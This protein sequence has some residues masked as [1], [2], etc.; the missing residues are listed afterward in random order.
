MADEERDH[1]LSI[2]IEESSEKIELSEDEETSSIYEEQRVYRTPS[3]LSF[4][5]EYS[6]EDKDRPPIRISSNHPNDGA[7]FSLEVQPSTGRKQEP[8]VTTLETNGDNRASAMVTQN[9]AVLNKPEEQ[10]EEKVRRSYNLY[11]ISSATSN[12]C[13]HFCY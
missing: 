1:P 11:W 2:P 5:S 13:Q 9:T 3:S 6:D 10:T 7:I 8:L 12:F 4:S